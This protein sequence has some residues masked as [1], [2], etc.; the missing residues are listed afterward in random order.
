MAEVIY[1]FSKPESVTY[2]IPVDDVVMGG[3]SR[4]ELV[5]SGGFTRFQGNLSLDQGGG[6]A[7]AR[8]RIEECNLS[9]FEG[10]E[11]RFRGD[12]KIYELRLQTDA[13]DVFYT[14]EFEALEQWQTLHMPFDTF[15]PSYRGRPVENALEIN[16]NRVMTFGLM[17]ANEQAGAFWLELSTL[18]AYT[19]D[20]R[21]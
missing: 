18:A 4:S 7:S 16:L 6:F 10:L 5:Y 3:V 17:I 20:E 1:D 9:R 21:P 2:L 8:S 11:L 15:L 12:G 13:R 19:A 14:A